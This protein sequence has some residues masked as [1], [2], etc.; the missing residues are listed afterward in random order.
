MKYSPVM[1][2][3]TAQM[4]NSPISLAAPKLPLI[5]RSFIIA[6]LLGV[7]L[8]CTATTLPPYEATYT[9]KLRGIKVN[10]TRKFES[11]TKDRYKVSWKAKALWM[12]LNE[13]S[14][15][16]LI[17]GKQIRPISYHYTRKG[18]GTDKPIHIVFDWENML[19]NASKG[20][21]KYQFALEPN[22][23]DR[24]SYQVQMQIDLLIKPN[25]EQF[26]YTVANHD[27]L[28]RYSF[29]FEKRE[30][31]ETKLGSASSLIFKREKKDKVTRIWLSPEQYY[32][33]VKIEQTEDNQSSVIAIK[34][35]KTQESSASGLMSFV[36]TTLRQNGAFGQNLN[37]SQN[38]NGNQN[39][40]DDISEAENTPPTPPI[41]DTNFDG[42]F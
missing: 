41:D 19:V 15:F 30:V 22:T 12:R 17:D 33:P 7:Q 1:A 16:E 26:D 40:N 25:S 18:L 5:L 11:T 27:R 35:W 10:G 3:K 39:F 23:L 38:L 20:D 24:L 42:D 29:N 37:D 32:V 34:N 6:L 13:W 14:E 9:T 8:G 4:P 2:L 28:A 31:I 21:K 36:P